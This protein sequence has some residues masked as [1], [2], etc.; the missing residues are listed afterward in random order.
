MILNLVQL[1]I[2]HHTLSF[3]LL[4]ITIKLLQFTVVFCL[5]V[6]LYPRQPY[7][8]SLY[9]RRFLHS[10]QCRAVIVAVGPGWRCSV[11]SQDLADLE[12]WL[13]G[14]EVADG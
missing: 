12:I 14:E 8:L 3:M 11:L 9:L 13:P 10:S 1:K 6:S 2:I 4:I 5:S 7:S